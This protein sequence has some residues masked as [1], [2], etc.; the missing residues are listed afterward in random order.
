MNK[1]QIE[2]IRTRYNKATSRYLT[3][4]EYREVYREWEGDIEML[5]DYIETLEAEIATDDKLLA[6]HKALLD[7]I[8]E[9]PDH[10][11]SCLPHAR[12]W[13]EKVQAENARLRGLLRFFVSI[14][15]DQNEADAGG[16]PCVDWYEWLEKAEAL[17]DDAP[18][19]PFKLLEDS[20]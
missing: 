17:F 6:D 14:D 19:C 2:E 18:D 13:V 7:K 1:Q 9:C 15:W 3:E 20:Q 8:P 16:T 5:L 4:A 10:G 11:S 12:E